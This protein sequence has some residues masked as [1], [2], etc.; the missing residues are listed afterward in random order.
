MWF[1]F[2]SLTPTEQLF[3]LKSAL[4]CC[5]PVEELWHHNTAM[6]WCAFIYRQWTATSCRK[7]FIHSSVEICTWF[8]GISLIL[9]CMCAGNSYKFQAGNRM[10]ALLWFKHLSAACQSNR[11]QVR[12]F[13]FKAGS[14]VIFCI[15][16]NN[17]HQSRYSVW[18]G[19]WLCFMYN[20]CAD[21]LLFK[22]IFFALSKL[23]RG[24][25]I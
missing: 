16:C 5:C 1:I 15:I 25:H 14:C 3:F 13:V 12:V 11:Q 19:R 24:R 17:K 21:L 20:F 18:S 9:S 10:N 22:Y 2:L 6:G 23:Y 4:Y 8:S 7:L